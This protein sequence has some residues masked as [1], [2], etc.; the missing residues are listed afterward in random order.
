MEAFVSEGGGK[1]FTL[2]GG[3]DAFDAS[4][5]RG[6]YSAMLSDVDVLSR[7]DRK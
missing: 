4:S 5:N 3:P 1:G 7:Y 6:A 2:V